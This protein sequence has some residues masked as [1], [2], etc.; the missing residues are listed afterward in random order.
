LGKKTKRKRKT[1]L[2]MSYIYDPGRF[3]FIIAFITWIHCIALH[4]IIS[5]GDGWERWVDPI[6]DNVLEATT[7]NESYGNATFRVFS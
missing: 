1:K 5:Q 7:M 3:Y 6:F 4:Y 2:D